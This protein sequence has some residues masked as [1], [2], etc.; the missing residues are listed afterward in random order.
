MQPARTSR[1]A[2][3]TRKKGEKRVYTDAIL[4][5]IRECIEYFIQAYDKVLELIADKDP[6]VVRLNTKDVK[7]AGR[8]LKRDHSREKAEN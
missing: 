5:Q 6:Y 1:C 2:T 7:A 4:T 3:I 8:R